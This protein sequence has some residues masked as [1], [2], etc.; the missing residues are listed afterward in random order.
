MTF[1]NLEQRVQKKKD[2]T[3]I[4]VVACVLYTNDGCVLVQVQLVL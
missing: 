1:Q 4:L 2:G 3:N